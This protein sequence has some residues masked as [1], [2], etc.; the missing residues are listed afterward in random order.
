[1]KKQIETT[2]EIHAP[3][4]KVWD[5]LLKTDSYSKWNPFISE[6]SDLLKPQ[7]KAK[8]VLN[9]PDG[10]HFKINPVI[11]SAEFPELRWKG[12]LFFNGIFD[13]EHYFRLKEIS[14]E[15]T[16]F[17]HGECFSGILVGFLGKVLEKTE[18]EPLY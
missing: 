16:L 18:E 15:K 5:I 12:K 7:Q 6:I 17:V 14:E 8:V 2:I 10:T 4:K 11:Q 13:G 9:L 1:M 3:A